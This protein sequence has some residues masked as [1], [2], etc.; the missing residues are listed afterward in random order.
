VAGVNRT[1]RELRLS[2]SLRMRVSESWVFVCV[3]WVPLE[4][5]EHLEPLR[6]L[7]LLVFKPSVISASPL[8]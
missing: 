8:K 6:L 5:L 4:H 3:G 1:S 2:L 7:I